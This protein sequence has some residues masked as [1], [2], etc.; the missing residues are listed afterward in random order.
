M[1]R[2]DVFDAARLGVR[3]AATRFTGGQTLGGCAV[4]LNPRGEM[5]LTLASYRTRWSLP[6]GYF[7]PGESSEVGITRELREEVGYAVNGPPIQVPHRSLHGKHVEHL[8]FAELDQNQ[9]DRLHPTSWE[10][11]SIR[12]CSPHS[13]PPLYSLTRS[14]VS[15]RTGIVAQS[16]PRWVPGPL[17]NAAEAS[18]EPFHGGHISTHHGQTNMGPS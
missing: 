5:L 6:G 8:G 11:R 9:A 16:G 1:N 10:I 3:V 4:L 7:E 2:H 17:V 15:E 14:L 12:W 18:A 13:M